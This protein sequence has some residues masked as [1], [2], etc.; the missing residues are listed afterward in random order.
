MTVENMPVEYGVTDAAISVLR[1]KYANMSIND[2]KEYRAVVGGI[3]ECR[4]LRVS[5][6]KRRKEL[7]ADALTWGRKVDGE[8]KR[9]TGLL[10]E[11]ETP[12][13]ALKQDA[14]E[15]KARIKAEKERIAR[16]KAE[17]EQRRVDNI[18]VRIDELYGPYRLLELNNMTSEQIAHA[19]AVFGSS[20]DDED[21]QEFEDEAKV[22]QQEAI[23]SAQSMLTAKKLAEEEAERQRIERE[24]IEAERREL[25]EAQRLERE[26]LEAER[27]ALEEQRRIEQE[28]ADAE[29]RAIEEEKR[30]IEEQK[31]AEEERREREEFERQAKILAEKEA[32]ERVEREAREKAAAEEAARIERER[33]EALRP[34]K[35]KM[36][37][38]AETIHGYPMP[39]V[40]SDEARHT[41]SA[42]QA[43]LVSV[44][45]FIRE[46]CECL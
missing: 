33:Q 39:E 5:V 21:F 38:L 36:L 26:K 1:D 10:T 27:R 23:T 8:A 13:K 25:E 28:K 30:K 32:E 22:K 29:R 37:A 7:K 20:F 44:A 11:I 14:D 43:K 42:A 45:E 40:A 46:Q 15:E 4:E 3:A 17:A 2:N 16:E 19:L 12:L 41:L 34:D 6:E 24:R 31:R 18:K 35:E 9:I